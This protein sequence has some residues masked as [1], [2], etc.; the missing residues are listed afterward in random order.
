MTS[1]GEPTQSRAKVTPLTNDPMS[2]AWQRFARAGSAHDFC[3]SWLDVQCHLVPQARSGIVVLRSDNGEFAPAAKWPENIENIDHLVGAVEA[4][5]R[6]ET[7][8]MDPGPDGT[9]MMAYPVRIKSD[10]FGAVVIEVGEMPAHELRRAFVNTS[11]GAGW[12]EVLFRR[13]QADTDSAE[14]KATRMALDL[15]AAAMEQDSLR[16]AAMALVNQIVDQLGPRSA[17]IAMRDG[18]KLRMLAFSRTA[19]FQNRSHL[20]I[21]ALEAMEEAIDQ[22]GPVSYPQVPGAEDRITVAQKR[23]AE[24]TSAGT[25]L[26]VPLME[27][28]KPVGGLLLEFDADAPP[29]PD[30]AML[31]EAVGAV[32]GSTLADKLRQNRLFAGRVPRWIGLFLRE[33]M[34]PRRVAG[35][36]LALVVVAAL[37]A[38]GMAKAP[39]RVTADAVVEGSIQRA[40]VAPIDGFLETSES[41][42][43]DI[44]QA[45]DILARLDD[46][47]LT[48][49]V[50]RLESEKTR[51]EGEYRAALARQETLET[52][53]LRATIDETNAQLRLVRLQFDRLAIRAPINGVIVSGDLTRELGSPIDKGQQLF[54]I[55]PLGSYRVVLKVDERDILLVEEGQE[56][57]LSLEAISGDRLPVTVAKVTPVSTPE[58]GRN[59][60]RVEAQVDTENAPLRPGMEG[61]G[62]VEIK[63]TALVWAWSRPLVNWLRLKLWTWLP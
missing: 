43:G 16:A 35:K 1:P 53:L 5:L 13:R 30:T 38:L 34:D 22:L 49:E 47:D 57:L 29:K 55:A 8:R 23:M 33:L 15:A 28:G 37:V 20:A 21:A 42:P 4:A 46:R 61:I 39:L 6:S 10:L 44:V 59:Y 7:G 52:A 50:L 31:V 3:R 2:E 18:R 56:G 17:A 62:K 14:V 26:S 48:L 11:W 32:S 51:A 63:E 12:L 19:W 25:I 9:V 41:R 27:A 36:I 24:A 45:G 54:E 58:E 40:I 60:F